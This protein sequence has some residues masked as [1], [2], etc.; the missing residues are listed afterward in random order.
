MALLILNK[1]FWTA[2]DWALVLG[3]DVDTFQR[4]ITTLILL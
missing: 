4:E 1:E 3:E 2:R